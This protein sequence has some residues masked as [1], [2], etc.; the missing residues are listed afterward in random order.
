[1]I[2]HHEDAPNPPACWNRDPGP[3]SYTRY[4]IDSQTGHT[5][6]LVISMDWA[7]QGCQS[8]APGIGQPT[9]DYPSG[10]PYPVAHGWLPWCLQCRQV[11]AEVV[12]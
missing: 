1:M 3:A 8:W 11:P 5:V 7:K 4:G 10:T 6:P 9:Q 2:V 12:A